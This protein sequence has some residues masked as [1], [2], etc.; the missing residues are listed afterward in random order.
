MA[1]TDQPGFT[2]QPGNAL[3]A[4]P[5]ALGLQRR[6]D[7]RRPVGVARGGVHIPHPREQRPVRHLAG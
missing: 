7:P 5:L 4:V 1:G 2:H 6:M 3:A